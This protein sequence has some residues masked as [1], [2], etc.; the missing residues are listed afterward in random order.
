MKGKNM[1]ITCSLGL[2]CYWTHRIR[3]ASKCSHS[4]SGTVEAGCSCIPTFS[5]LHW[6]T[7]TL[8]YEDSKLQGLVFKTLLFFNITIA[9]TDQI[10]K[11]FP[12]FVVNLTRLKI[13]WSKGNLSVDSEFDTQWKKMCTTHLTA[14]DDSLESWQPLTSA[15][16]AH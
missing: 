16:T 5:L 14:E 15:F 7:P 8:Q 1:K 4:N 11:N 13:F 6:V 10:L 3:K 2:P 9:I 12:F